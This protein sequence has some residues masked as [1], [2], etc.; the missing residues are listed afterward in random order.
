MSLRRLAKAFPAARAL[1]LLCLVVGAPASGRTQVAD[2]EKFQKF[3]FS[4]THKSLM[5]NALAAIS[6]VVFVRCPTLVSKGS[7]VKPLKPILF[8][9][10]GVPSAGVWKE[11]LPIA[12]CGNDT[13]LNM[14]FF[15][16]NDG[17]IKALVGFPGFTRADLTLQRDALKYA[18]LG[19]RSKATACEH[20]D[21]KHT[22]FEG[23][24]LP[25]RQAPDPGPNQQFRP[26]RETWIMVG[27]GHTLDVP[28]E[29]IPGA[30]GTTIAQT[31]NKV[32]MH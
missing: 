13:V 21:V 8:G 3:L 2:A 11:E 27:C 7:N 24:G 6:P 29:F 12:G 18:Y 22:Q 32:V 1:L 4:E 23:F 5:N 30:N 19:A 10:D 20:F 14:Y 31:L 26:W 16:G 15:A 28:M 9:E 25:D 17:K